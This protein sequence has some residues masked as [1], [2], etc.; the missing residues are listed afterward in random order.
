MAQILLCGSAVRVHDSQ[1]YKKMDATSQHISCILELRKI[2]LFSFQS[3]TVAV[4]CAILRV[5]Q[6]WNPRQIQFS[7]CTWSLWLSKAF[8]R[9]LCS[10]CWC[11]CCCLSSTWSFRHWSPCRRLRRLCRGTPHILPVLLPL[12]LSH[13]CH[14]ESGDWWLL[15]LQ[16]WQCLRDLPRY[17]PWS[18]PGK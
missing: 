15:S 5:S 6:V 11:S 3:V 13:R 14:Q 12:L 8:V 7:P 9:L 1:A 4:V 10:P 17:M 18:F 16:W 2:M